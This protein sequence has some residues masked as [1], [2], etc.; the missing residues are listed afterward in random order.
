MPHKGFIFFH[1]NAVNRIS[2]DLPVENCS[3]LGP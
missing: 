3:R 1:N 2:R